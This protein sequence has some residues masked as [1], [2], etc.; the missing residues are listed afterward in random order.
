MNAKRV[1]AMLLAGMLACAPVSVLAETEWEDDPAEVVW[2]LWNVG[3]VAT[4]DGIQ[5][6][7]D[8]LNEITLPKINVEVD[9]E[10][11][12]MGTYMTQMPMESSAGTQVDLITAFPAGAGSYAQMVANK[13]LLPLDDLLENEAPE[14]VDL[15]SEEFLKA[16]QKDGVTYAVPVY[17][18][19]TNDLYWN[20]R[21]SYIE[22]AG[23]NPEDIH[24][25]KD[26]TE[27]FAKVHELH[28]EMK[29]ISTGGQ[30]LIGSAGVLF[31][32]VTYDSLG[33]TLA[34]VMIEDD[35]A[36]VVSLLETD[37]YKEMLSVLNDWYA[38]GYIDMDAPIRE[39]DPTSDTS[40]FS[41]WLAGNPSRTLATDTAAG[42][43]LTHVNLTHGCISTGT[44]TI[45]TMGIPVSAEEPEGAAR[46]MNLC[47][48]DP[49]VKNL[50]SFGIEGVDYTL[51][52][53][54]AVIEAEGAA[55][56]PNTT[57]IFGNQFL[58][59]PAE[60]LLDAGIDPT[61]VNPDEWYYSPLYG[62]SIDLEK[63]A[64]QN[65]QLQ[66]VYGEFNPTVSCGFGT[67]ETYQNYI[68]K[69]YA[70]GMQEYL[71]EIQ[72]Q[73]DEYLAGQE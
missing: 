71:D 9:L 45:L 60:D 19:A 18:D 29:M 67:E 16:T 37:A 73:L 22:E 26:I 54:G 35:A 36:K 70:S 12:D 24:D 31:T 46:L 58:S 57:G 61:D 52:D 51:R 42:E 3:G 17:M 59:H 50:I 7:E 40:V 11:L 68:D 4:P 49:E 20:A 48:T 21:T 14:M 1:F 32:G 69:L 27:V 72:K 53:D 10:I 25:Y 34:A 39:D 5:A 66:N 63:I 8:A 2:Y 47:Y 64:G 62:F 15:L 55:Y 23:F 38:A 56:N 30:G 41:F 13:Q 33:T 28:P 44:S 65:T 6:V 43:P